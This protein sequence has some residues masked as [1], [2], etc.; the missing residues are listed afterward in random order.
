MKV[1]FNDLKIGDQF[2]VNG[3]YF[4]KIANARPGIPPHM[5]GAN[6]IRFSNRHYMVFC[7]EAKVTL[8]KM[9]DNH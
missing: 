7:S 2:E 4:V 5:Q 8:A 9:V 6:A 3:E 1:M